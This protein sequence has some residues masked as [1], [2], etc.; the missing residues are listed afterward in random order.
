MYVP[1][2]KLQWTKK[3]HVEIVDIAQAAVIK[4]MTKRMIC[5]TRYIK[6]LRSVQ[7][8]L[9]SG[10]FNG[11]LHL[12][13]LKSNNVMLPNSDMVILLNY[14]NLA[15]PVIVRYCSQYGTCNIGLN[16][17]II[18]WTIPST[19]YTINDLVNWTKQIRD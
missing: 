2:V 10:L 13:Q 8:A 7:S 11:V 16:Q 15:N 14:L 5:G 9:Y 1:H 3:G 4:K 12:V 18:S 17:N 6:A 19:S